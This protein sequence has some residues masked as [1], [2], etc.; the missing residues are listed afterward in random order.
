MEIS[1]AYR[2][3]APLLSAPLASFDIYFQQ[4]AF[5]AAQAALQALPVKTHLLVTGDQ[6]A[7]REYHVHFV[8]AAGD[9]FARVSA[10]AISMSSLPCGS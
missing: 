4:Y 5:A 3:P 2:I 9:R 10:S 1:E 8:S 6:R 7:V